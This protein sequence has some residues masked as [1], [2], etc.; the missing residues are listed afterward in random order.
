MPRFLQPGSGA[1]SGHP[2]D[3]GRRTTKASQARAR[4]GRQGG[5]PQT[6]GQLQR[7]LQNVT[8]PLADIQVSR[9]PHCPVTPT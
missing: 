8:V 9:W 7:E 5:Q 2:G 1:T 4:Q 3:T 6:P